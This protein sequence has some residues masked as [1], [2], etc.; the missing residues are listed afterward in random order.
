MVGKPTNNLKFKNCFFRAASIVKNSDN[1]KYVNNGY[2]IIFDSAFL[3]SFNNDIA[4][5]V[6]IFTANNSSSSHTDN[7]KN[8]FLVLSEGPVFGINGGF[9]IEVF[10]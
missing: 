4:R 10:H 2:G 5:N 6:I 3:W 7:H 9:E 8:K 1:E